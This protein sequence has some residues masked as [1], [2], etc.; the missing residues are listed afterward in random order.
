MSFH[1]YLPRAHTPDSTTYTAREY[2]VIVSLAHKARAASDVVKFMSDKQ[3]SER[4]QEAKIHIYGLARKKR[5]NIK[6]KRALANEK[7]DKQQ[8]RTV[9]RKITILNY[10]QQKI[11]HTQ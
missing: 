10:I 1:S 2:L 4:E 11:S 6:K 8:L 5:E 3:A 7:I 9:A